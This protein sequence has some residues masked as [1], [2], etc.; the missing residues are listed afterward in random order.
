MRYHK[1]RVY[2]FWYFQQEDCQQLS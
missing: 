1:K 2:P